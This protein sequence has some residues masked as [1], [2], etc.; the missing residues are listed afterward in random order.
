MVVRG[1]DWGKWVKM[2]KGNQLL[3]IRR[4]SSGDVIYNMVTVVNSTVLYI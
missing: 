1:E 4:S 3:C 2:V